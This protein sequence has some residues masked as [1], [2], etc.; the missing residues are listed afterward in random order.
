[1]ARRT[2]SEYIIEIQDLSL[3]EIKRRYPAIGQDLI[4]GV[5]SKFTDAEGYYFSAKRDKSGHQ[6]RSKNKLD[7]QID[8]IKPM[9]K[10]GKTVPENLQLLTRAENMRKS[11]KQQR[12]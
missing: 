5:Y 2:D 10:G 9:S 11:D 8:H 3:H 1:M 6:Y 7:F 12:F 4:D